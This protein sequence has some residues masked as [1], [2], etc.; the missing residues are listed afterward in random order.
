MFGLGVSAAFG[1]LGFLKKH[2]VKIIIGAVAVAIVASLVG[3]GWWLRGGDVRALEAKLE[4][5]AQK[6]KDDIAAWERAEEGWQKATDKQN[7]A[8]TRYKLLSIESEAA[9]VAAE[10]ELRKTEAER[11]QEA[12]EFDSRLVGMLSDLETVEESMRCEVFA[13]QAAD[14][15]NARL[16]IFRE[17]VGGAP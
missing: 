6:H 12:A 3:A 4:L 10:R 14:E 8:V 7:R 13:G 11:V 5:Q 15:W 1:A 9:L 2:L 17:R 16:G